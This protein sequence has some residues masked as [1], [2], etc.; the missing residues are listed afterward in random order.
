[1]EDQKFWEMVASFNWPHDDCDVAK[2]RAMRTYT[3]DQIREFD[4]EF[5]KKRSDVGQA[6][7]H[8]Q[9]GREV[10]YFLGSDGFSDL[11]CHIVGLGNEVYEASI[12][13]PSL[14]AKRAETNDYV[15][16]FSYAIPHYG[17]KLSFDE[18]LKVRYAFIPDTQELFDEYQK[19]GWLAE[20]FYLSFS[21]LN[22]L[23][24]SFEGLQE[25]MK[26]KYLFER[27]GDWRLINRKYWS[28]IGRR[29]ADLMRPFLDHE[30]IDPMQTDGPTRVYFHAQR[31]TIFFNALE[32]QD[33]EG[34]F[35]DEASADALYDWWWLYRAVE[36]GSP[37]YAPTN[38]L[39]MAKFQYMGENYIND[40]RRYMAGLPGFPCRHHYKQI[41]KEE[42]T[43]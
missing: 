32:Y 36:T 4:Q 30:A 13:D 35:N 14:I 22:K 7:E 5:G 33:F 31:F 25:F 16:S 18:W 41:L 24:E 21:D 11:T 29:M 42:I 17:I 43:A 34:A 10:D 38:L 40:F 8:W 12:A 20:Q 1:M 15:E 39:P 9:K 2:A 26:E 19:H 3:Q 37:S 6:L 27:L 28:H 23:P